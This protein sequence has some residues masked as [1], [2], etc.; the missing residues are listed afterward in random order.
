MTGLSPE[1]LK[2][3][4]MHVSLLCCRS[5]HRNLI[6]EFQIEKKKHDQRSLATSSSHHIRK[7]THESL[8]DTRYLCHEPISSSTNI[9]IPSA[10]GRG[11]GRHFNPSFIPSR[12][13]QSL[14][15]LRQTPLPSRPFERFCGMRIR[16]APMLLLSGLWGCSA[17][18][19][20]TSDP[21][22]GKS[23]NRLGSWVVGGIIPAYLW[24]GVLQSHGLWRG[25]PG[26]GKCW[27]GIIGGRKYGGGQF[28]VYRQ[29]AC[30]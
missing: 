19:G 28:Y 18:T 17:S 5:K 4:Q 16:N 6:K 30:E 7:K 12:R 10:R 9:C 11:S 13:Q 3:T 20:C 23:G 22:V 25:K 8:P 24:Q 15:T 21:A 29:M 27:R 14:G 26:V 1:I 2:S